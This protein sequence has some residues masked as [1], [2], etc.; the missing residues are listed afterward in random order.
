MSNLAQPESQFVVCDGV[1]LHY[2]VLGQ[3]TNR[4]PIIFTHGGGPGSTAWSNFR[5]N[6]LAL[7]A[8]YQCYFLD[9][10]QFGRSQ[11]L[12]IEGPVFTW[13]A[14]VLR[15]FMDVLGIKQ[16]HLVNQSFGGCVALRF[17]ADYP[18]RVGR[19]ITIGS[20]PVDQGVLQPLPLLSKHAANLMSDYY[21]ADGGPSLNKMRNLMQKYEL[22]NDKKIDEEA[23]IL[24]FEASN[25]PGYIQL[26]QTPRAFGEWENLLP[27][28]KDIKAPVLMCWGLHDWFGGIDV[29]VMI[30]N[31]LP[32]GF[33]HIFGAAAHHLQSECPDE[34]NNLAISFLG[35]HT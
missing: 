13:H 11:M 35:A 26:L 5:L 19:M 7:S 34:F 4:P 14:Q 15:C 2:Q 8:Y 29:P 31:R 27:V 23:V 25:N 21:F 28:L 22:H 3:A 10:A 17:A 33:L 24:R 9:F 32:T 18:E 12:A 30:L 16:S 1:L 20:Q 6:A